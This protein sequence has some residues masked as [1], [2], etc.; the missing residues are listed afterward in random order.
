MITNIWYLIIIFI[1]ILHVKHIYEIKYYNTSSI[2]QKVHLD[3]IVSTIN[4]TIISYDPLL[5]P[6]KFEEYNN[7][8]NKPNNYYIESDELLRISDFKD[9]DLYIFKN[10]KL[11]N[12]LGINTDKIINLTSNILTCNICNYASIIKGYYKTKILKQIHNCS[13]ISLLNGN[14]TVYLFN[15]KHTNSILKNKNDL[16]KLKK[17]AIIHT[18]E[19]N[20]LVYIPV[21]WYY[22]LETNQFSELIHIE[23][24]N[25]FTILYNMFQLINNND[26]N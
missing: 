7:I 19:I 1:I 6:H 17:W 22:I 2:I 21:N 11:F 8:Y 13:I 24:D 25:Y 5:I 12:D 10:T 9:K 4:N 16:N 3:E 23:F 26:D 14:C 15:P 18:M 20:E